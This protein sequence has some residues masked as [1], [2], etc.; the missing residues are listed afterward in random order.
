MLPPL[1]MNLN[2]NDFDKVSY[3][4]AAAPALQA[5]VAIPE[6]VPAAPTDESFAWGIVGGV[7]G[8]IL[9]AA[10]YVAFIQSTNIRI[11]YLAILVAFLVAKGIMIGSKAKGGFQYQVA[12]VLMTY[13]TVSVGNAINIYLFV[14]KTRAIDL[15]PQ[16][17]LDLFRYGVADPFLRFQSSGPRALIGLLI[18]FVGL[19][20][21]WRMTS[22]N[23]D[24]MRHP[25]LR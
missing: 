23:W 21:A 3:V 4:D 16:N 12:A 25:F 8:G 17:I 14:T 18:L 9:G 24:E 5:A 10:V 2:P 7:A 13:G 22:G 15:T 20:A 19:R 1:L 11:G 6:P